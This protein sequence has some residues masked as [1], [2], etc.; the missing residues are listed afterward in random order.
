MR[1]NTA[2]LAIIALPL[3]L[4]A[5]GTPQDRC[6]SR[7][8]DEYRTVSALLAE[9]EGNI[10]RG[11]SWEERQVVR[12]RFGQCRDVRRD[13]DGNREIVT[14]GCWRDYVDEERYRVPIDPAAEARKR[15][16]LASRKAALA[17]SAASAVS[18]CRAAF[19]EE[20]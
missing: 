2:P 8:T 1:R 6:I 11:Y 7:N 20:T 16:N 12:T 17:P 13:K 10:A 14:R 3:L 15:D 9:V 4:A 18:A 5:C 19:P